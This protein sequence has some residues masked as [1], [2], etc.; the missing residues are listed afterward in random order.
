MYC[1]G[2]TNYSFTSHPPWTMQCSC[3]AGKHEVCCQLVYFFFFLLSFPCLLCWCQAFALADAKSL[4]S[5]SSCLQAVW[6]KVLRNAISGSN[7]WT[8]QVE[9]MPS[10]EAG[11]SCTRQWRRY[12]VTQGSLT[13]HRVTS[14][15]VSIPFKI[16]KTNFFQLNA[17]LHSAGSSA[18]GCIFQK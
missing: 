17:N 10:C 11:T 1:F 4:Y 13:C 8:V 7:P 14:Y 3:Q 6:T 9:A 12:Q 15:D 18:T 16:A 5:W 2:S